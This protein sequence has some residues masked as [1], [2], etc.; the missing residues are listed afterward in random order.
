[1]TKCPSG[2]Q[3]EEFVSEVEG[4]WF[5]HEGQCDGT[6]CRGDLIQ[7]TGN[8]RMVTKAESF[9]GT[10]RGVGQRHALTLR[11]QSWNEAPL[12]GY[13]YLGPG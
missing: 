3:L 5:K 13:C 1:M 6:K 4:S 7:G 11:L 9:R 12:A 2:A 8:H 10:A